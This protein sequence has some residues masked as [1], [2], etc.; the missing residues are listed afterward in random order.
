MVNVEIY[1]EDDGKIKGFLV[2]GHAGYKP[3]GQDIVCAGVS[4]LTQTA[5]LGL[6]EY[7]A[8]P[9]QVEKKPGLLKCILPHG[10]SEEENHQAQVILKTMAL[11]LEATA[12]SYSDYVT[13]HRRRW[14]KC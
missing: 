12:H 13:V 9:P 6:Y 3:H 7:L 5:V 14:S 11:G 8:Q 1:Q 4:I 2:K 10:L